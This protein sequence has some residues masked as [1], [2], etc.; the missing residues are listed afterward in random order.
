MDGLTGTMFEEEQRFPGSGTSVHSTLQ[1][2]AMRLPRF[3]YLLM[4]R[5][6]YSSDPSG[7]HSRPRW[8]QFPKGWQKI[9]NNKDVAGGGCSPSS[10]Q[11]FRRYTDFYMVLAV[12]SSTFEQSNRHVGIAF[13]EGTQGLPSV[14]LVV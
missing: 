12:Y 2:G 11:F 14:H 13:G 5:V 1:V 10:L 6:E 8:S 3:L 4:A 9:P 7:F